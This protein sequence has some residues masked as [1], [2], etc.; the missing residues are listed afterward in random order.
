[1]LYP[2]QGLL[3]I[4]GLVPFTV[5]PSIHIAA[6]LGFWLRAQ[7]KAYIVISHCTIYIYTQYGKPDDHF[8][9]TTMEQ[10]L[11]SLCPYK[12]CIEC[13]VSVAF[14]EV[15]NSHTGRRPTMVSCPPC[16]LRTSVPAVAMQRSSHQSCSHSQHDKE[17]GG[18]PDVVLMGLP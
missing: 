4:L 5:H 14:P 11:L 6:V 8:P 13:T 7:I 15:R 18:H 17:Y 12:L 2:C 9:Y 10:A 1:M 16:L 3:R